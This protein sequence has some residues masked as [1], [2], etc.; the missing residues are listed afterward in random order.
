LDVG[1]KRRTVPP[2]IRRALDHRDKGCRFPGC[3][4][5][6]TDAHHITHWADGGETKLENLILLCRRHHRAVHEEGV[7]VEMTEGGAEAGTVDGAETGT[8]GGLD[9]GP[10]RFFRP[11]GR[12]IPVVP[13]P[14]RLPAEPTID[15]VRAHRER[16]IVPHRWTATPL[17]NG[18]SLDY[19]LAIDML[20]PLKA[21]GGMGERLNGES[22][23]GETSEE[24]RE[25]WRT[26]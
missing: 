5:R 26:I 1:R 23:R 19:G 8:G 24:T 18:E 4:C 25:E 22:S 3:G 15:L 14:P 10:V 6:Y 20:R 13:E 17:W 21:P 16:G 9:G 2:A 7:R 12:A 11:D